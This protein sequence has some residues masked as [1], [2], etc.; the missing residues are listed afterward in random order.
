[1]KRKSIAI[2]SALIASL[3]AVGLAAPALA[4]RTGWTTD[5]YAT[6][7]EQGTSAPNQGQYYGNRTPRGNQEGTTDGTQYGPYGMMNGYGGYGMMNGY[8]PHARGGG[9]GMM[10]GY[11]PNGMVNSGG[12]GY[13]GCNW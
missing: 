4:Q 9:Y 7:A 5:T 12:A 10:N 6:S 3:F 8:G 1:M 13:G 11:G 2:K